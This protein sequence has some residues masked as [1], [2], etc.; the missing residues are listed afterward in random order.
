LC[1]IAP[2]NGL[3]AT[4]VVTNEVATTRFN[5][6][7]EK[8]ILPLIKGIFSW[9]YSSLKQATFCMVKASLTIDKQEIKI[10]LNIKL[11]IFFLLILLD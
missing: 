7:V 6:A 8:I 10:Y 3:S 4:E 5:M 2:K 9:C 1:D 11:K